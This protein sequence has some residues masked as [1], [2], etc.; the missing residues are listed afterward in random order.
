MEKLSFFVDTDGSGVSESQ[1]LATIARQVPESFLA[2]LSWDTVKLDGSIARFVLAKRTRS[3][4]LSFDLKEFLERGTFNATAAIRLAR[5]EETVRQFERKVELRVGQTYVFGSRELELSAS[6]Y[7]SHIRD[8][9]GSEDRGK[10]Y[11][12][13]RPY[14][15]FLVVAVTPRLLEEGVPASAPVAVSIDPSR[16]PK[17]E[18]PLPIPLVGEIVLELTLDSNGAPTDVKV[19]RSSLPEVNARILGEAM[20]FR[21]P[22][23]AGKKARLTLPLHVKP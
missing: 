22:E 2:T 17:M 11:E 9:E 20:S 1:W 5:G 21:F 12:I 18:S 10:L 15:F 6:E 3:L 19:L 8:F 4:E 13:L 7:L 23:A 14:S 16:I